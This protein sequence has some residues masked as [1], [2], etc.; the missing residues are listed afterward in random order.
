M[1]KKEIDVVVVGAD[2]VAANGDVVNK[3]GTY[4]LSVLAKENRIP[5]FV[6]CPLSTNCLWISDICADGPPTEKK[7]MQSQ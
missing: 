7:P 4:T 2:R 3:I 1:N 5:F 6:A